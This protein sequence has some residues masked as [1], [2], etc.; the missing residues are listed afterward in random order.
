MMMRRR[1]SS[2]R[3]AAWRRLGERVLRP[4]DLQVGAETLGPDAA[5]EAAALRTP[6]SLIDD[7]EIA[8]LG[9]ARIGVP[10]VH[11]F[12]RHASGGRGWR[13][14]DGDG[15]GGGVGGLREAGDG[16]GRVEVVADQSV[17]EP[18]T[19]SHQGRQWVRRRRGRASLSRRMLESRDWP[20]CVEV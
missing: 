7:A 16:S 8:A 3:A 4:E 5:R 18:V 11:G 10:Q 15:S 6:P 12:E 2:S 20:R 1:G 14:G 13:D 17:E 19:N 9:V